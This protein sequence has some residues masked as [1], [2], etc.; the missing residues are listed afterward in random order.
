MYPKPAASA[1]AAA[2]RNVSRPN[3]V[4]RTPNR[5]PSK[6]SAAMPDRFA[7]LLGATFGVCAEL[8]RVPARM[9][10]TMVRIAVIMARTAKTT[11]AAFFILMAPGF[12][13][14]L[15]TFPTR[16]SLD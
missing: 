10:A 13:H 12:R 5:H 7:G 9:T 14:D 1:L 15:T 8:V 2:S 6:F 4:D 3:A 11:V 16:F